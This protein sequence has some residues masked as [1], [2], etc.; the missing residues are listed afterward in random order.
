MVYSIE[1]PCAMVVKTWICFRTTGP[2]LNQIVKVLSPYIAVYLLNYKLYF[3]LPFYKSEDLAV[4][5]IQYLIIKPQ[6]V[7]GDYS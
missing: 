7:C 3:H 4:K 5:N 6:E 1:I 2:Q